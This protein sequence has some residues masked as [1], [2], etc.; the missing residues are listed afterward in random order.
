MRVFSTGKGEET[1]TG[2]EFSKNKEIQSKKAE[3]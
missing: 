2:K 3:N 1:D